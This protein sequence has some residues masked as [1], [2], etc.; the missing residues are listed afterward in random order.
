DLPLNA[1][2][3]AGH[4]NRIA[5]G[6][7]GPIS[8]WTCGTWCPALELATHRAHPLAVLVECRFH[9]HPMVTTDE[10][11]LLNA[12]ERTSEMAIVRWCEVVEIHTALVVVAGSSDNLEHT[13]AAGL[14]NHI[15]SAVWTH[16]VH[17]GGD[18]PQRDT[19][20]VFAEDGSVDAVGDGWRRR[21]RGRRGG[22]WVIARWS[23]ARWNIAV[24]ALPLPW[25]VPSR[26]HRAA[27]DAAV[28]GRRHRAAS[29]AARRGRHRAACRAVRGRGHGAGIG[30]SAVRAGVCPRVAGVVDRHVAAAHGLRAR[31]VDAAH[32]PGDR[33]RVHAGV[34]ARPR[35][36]RARQGAPVLGHRRAV[37]VFGTGWSAARE[38]QQRT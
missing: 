3:G 32:T 17:G 7:I 37:V 22:R 21:G 16:A 10:R 27:G 12:Y 24:S 31:R 9:D 38:R 15:D 18:G 26:L 13:P 1:F 34:G 25:V 4:R 29:R 30:G 8:R 33:P 23:I 5:L 6:P 28:C 20:E 2:P 14:F 11:K 36:R 35:L 19:V